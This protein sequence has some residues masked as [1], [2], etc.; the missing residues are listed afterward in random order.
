[1]LPKSWTC[2]KIENKFA[3]SNRMARK[4]KALVKKNGIF[5]KLLN[6]SVTERVYSF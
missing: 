6:K 2:K 3:I 5:V 1:V 4:V